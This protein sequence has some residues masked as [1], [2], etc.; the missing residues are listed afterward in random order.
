LKASIEE[1]EDVY[2]KL[3]EHFEKLTELNGTETEKECQFR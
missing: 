1:F 2:W 3:D